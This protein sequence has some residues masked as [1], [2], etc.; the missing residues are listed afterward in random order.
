MYSFTDTGMTDTDIAR[1]SEALSINGTYIE[2]VID[3]YRTLTVSGRE[4][5]SMDYDEIR[6]GNHLYMENYFQDSRIIEIEYQLQ[7]ETPQKLMEKYNKLN[8]LLNFKEAQL[9]FADEPDKYFVGSKA[10]SEP[11]PKGRLNITSTFSIYCPDPHKYSAATKQ[12]T[13][14]KNA[15]GVLELTI[16][17]KGTADV[18]INYTV[19]HNHDNGFLGFVTDRGV[20]QT[21][22]IDEVDLTPYKKSEELIATK[23]FS[24]FRRDTGANAQ[25]ESKITNGTLKVDVVN[26]K[27]CLMID[28]AGS[29]TGMTPHGGMITVDIPPDSE[30]AVGASDF[31]C[32]LNI[33][34]ETGMIHQIG[35]MGVNWL[36]END[37]LIFSYIVEKVTQN[38]NSARVTMSVGGNKQNNYWTTYFPPTM[39]DSQNPMNESRGAIDVLKQG[40]QIGGYYWGVRHN[41][42][43][44]ELA[45]V[46]CKRIQMYMGKYGNSALVTR[47]YLREFKFQK[48]NVQK[49]NDN[50]NRYP[51]GSKV[52]ID[53]KEGKVYTDGILRMDDEVK[54]SQYFFAPPGQSKVQIYHSNFSVP[55]PDVTATIR[56]AWL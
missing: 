54:G 22:K 30:G 34:F 2:N 32:W 6:I 10:E 12:F 52:E 51:K 48:L 15:D 53:G 13:A 56:E 1:P 33:W 26:G 4:T 42:H 55:E 18:P 47:M 25:D 41:I 21:G 17:N 39:Y 14:V 27:N 46:K 43:V 23:D 44:P 8:G 40:D 20:L 3:G 5:H 29:G 9:I 49:W 11:P 28:D 35:T 19:K 7:A 16:D 24:G 38:V 31:Y 36:D 50:P 37:N 45:N